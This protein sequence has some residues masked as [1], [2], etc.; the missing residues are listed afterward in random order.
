MVSIGFGKTQVRLI[1]L[2]TVD[3]EL[4]PK[5]EIRNTLI[6]IQLFNLLTRVYCSN[7]LKLKKIGEKNK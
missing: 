3:L 5:P 1:I 2:R 6:L 4:D 7:L